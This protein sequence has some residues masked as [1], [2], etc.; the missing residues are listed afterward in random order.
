MLDLDEQSLNDRFKSTALSYVDGA[1]QTVTLSATQRLLQNQPKINL[2]ETK[3]WVR[4]TISPGD[5]EQDTLELN[6]AYKQLGTAYL[7]VFAP[8]GTGMGA[9]RQIRD[10]FAAA[11]RGWTS[12][13]GYTSVDRIGYTTVDQD[14]YTQINV[15]VSW[16][17]NRKSN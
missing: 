13:D 17:S 5:S 12:P 2:D 7:Q 15:T 10:K 11:F 6:P 1:G 14:A 4:F 16:E 3:P 9:A 8:K